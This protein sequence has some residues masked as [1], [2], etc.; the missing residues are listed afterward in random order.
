MSKVKSFFK[1]H[2]E[3][4]KFIKFSFAGASSSILEIAV[5]ALL[6]Y[7]V[8]SS[9]REVPVRDNA[10]LNLLGIEYKAYLYSYFISTSIGYFAAF[11]MNRKLTFR[12]DVNALT[13]GIMYAAMVLFTIA[14]NTWVGSYLGTVV[15]NK[16]WD[17]FLV[18]IA[19]KLLVMTLPTLWTYPLSRFVIFRKKKPVEE[20]EEKV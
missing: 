2:G 13:S 5:Y 18:D 14:V 20:P 1:N 4:W 15:T 16:G 11:L 9:L 19:L 12:S 6:L 3:V 10:F 17:N 8:F 7:G